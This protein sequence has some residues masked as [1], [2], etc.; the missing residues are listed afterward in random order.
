MDNIEIQRWDRGS[1]LRDRNPN[2]WRIR[3]IQHDAAELFGR[4]AD[5]G[6]ISAAAVDAAAEISPSSA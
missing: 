3:P 5:D 1:V 4:Y 2:R 6:E